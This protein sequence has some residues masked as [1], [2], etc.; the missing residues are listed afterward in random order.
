MLKGRDIRAGELEARRQLLIEKV[1]PL[2]DE[3]IRLSPVLDGELPD[4]IHP[5]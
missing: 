3:P 2:L 4:L 1:L 5:R